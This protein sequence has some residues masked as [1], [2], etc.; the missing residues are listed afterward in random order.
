MGTLHK[1]GTFCAKS[2]QWR[3]HQ[4]TDSAVFILFYPFFIITYHDPVGPKHKNICIMTLYKCY[5]NVLCLLSTLE[6]TA[7]WQ[8][9]VQI[10]HSCPNWQR[11]WAIIGLSHWHGGYLRWS[12]DSMTSSVSTSSSGSVSSSMEDTLRTTRPRIWLWLNLVKTWSASSIGNT[13][14]IGGT[15]WK[16]KCV[17]QKIHIESNNHTNNLFCGS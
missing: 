10:R 8:S 11:H 15:I 4:Y 1:G 6:V 2:R 3:K 12:A 13:L 17:N 16:T 9:S 5:A 7:S 14:Y